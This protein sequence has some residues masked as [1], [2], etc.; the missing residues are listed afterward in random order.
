MIDPKEVRN[1]WEAWR[2]KR[3]DHQD[4][5]AT[6]ADAVASRPGLDWPAFVKSVCDR[7]D[8]FD[9]DPNPEKR[10]YLGTLSTFLK[11]GKWE[12]QLPPRPL[13]APMPLPADHPSRTKT[14]RPP[15]AIPPFPGAVFI[16]RY[17]SGLETWRKPCDEGKDLCLCDAWKRGT[18]C[19]LEKAA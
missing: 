18:K 5:L 19:W 3:P 7:L 8:T 9:E 13:H 1:L 2:A 17:P 15:D 16:A 10:K 6:F 4:F 14:A 12:E 11:A